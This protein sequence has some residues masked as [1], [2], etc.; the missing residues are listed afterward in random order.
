[1][2]DWDAQPTKALKKVDQQSRQQLPGSE[3]QIIQAMAGKIL[4]RLKY[5]RQPR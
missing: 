4:K 1:L 2:Q 5:L 3:E